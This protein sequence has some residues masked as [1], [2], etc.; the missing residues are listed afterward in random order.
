MSA[1]NVFAFPEPYVHPT[2]LTF[3]GV[4]VVT[5]FLFKTGMMAAAVLGLPDPL[6]CLAAITGG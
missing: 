2:D 4:Y 5:E 1:L 6:G 3:C